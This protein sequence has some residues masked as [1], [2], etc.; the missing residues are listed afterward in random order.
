MLA[1]GGMLAPWACQPTRPEGG[2]AR[3]TQG[4]RRGGL[5]APDPGRAG[6]DDGG[7]LG[8]ADC[9]ESICRGLTQ[10]PHQGPQLAADAGKML[11]DQEPGFEA[12]A[13]ADGH[14]RSGIPTGN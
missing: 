8:G 3:R 5:A 4:H 10:N 9:N 13:H 11:L 2:G 7:N 1:L 12:S 6:R 14:N